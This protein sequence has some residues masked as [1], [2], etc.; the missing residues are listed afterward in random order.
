MILSN[1]WKTESFNVVASALKLKTDS[2][3]KKKHNCK[4]YLQN[5]FYKSKLFLLRLKEK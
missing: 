4:I 2:K 1:Q 3:I 5:Y